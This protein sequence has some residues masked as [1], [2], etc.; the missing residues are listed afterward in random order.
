MS[1]ALGTREPCSLQTIVVELFQLD[2]AASYKHAFGYIRQLAISLRNA[3]TLKKKDSYQ[4][5]YNWQFIHCIRGIYVQ[6]TPE[7]THCC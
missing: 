3:I 4:Q 1:C 5:V 7:L 2:P 6:D